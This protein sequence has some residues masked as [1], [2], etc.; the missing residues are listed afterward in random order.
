[1]AWISNKRGNPA[2]FWRWF[3][4]IVI[5]YSEILRPE[6]FIHK[7]YSRGRYVGLSSQ[8]L[9]FQVRTAPARAGGSAIYKANR[10]V[11]SAKSR[12][13]ILRP[14]NLTLSLSRLLLGVLSKKIVNTDKGQFSQSPT[15]F[16]HVPGLPYKQK[17]SSTVSRL[18]WKPHC[19][20]SEVRLLVTISP[21]YPGIGQ[22][23]ET[24]LFS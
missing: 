3:V 21:Q 10:T 1:M 22:R 12:D 16:P 20:S 9:H 14:L 18:G 6:S 5:F 4:K 19:S 13:E 2:F 15:P 11:S 23:M 17:N 8:L 24:E 7:L